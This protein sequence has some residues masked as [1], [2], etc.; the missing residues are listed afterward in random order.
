MV[1][2]LFLYSSVYSCHLFLISSASV[3]FLSLPSFTVPILTWNVPFLSPIFLKRSLVFPILLFSSISL[4][5]SLKKAYLSLLFS[6]T[7]HSVGY[8]FPCL[9]CFLHIFFPQLFVRPPQTTTLSWISFSLGW[10][11]SLTP[12]QCYKLLLESQ[13]CHSEGACITQLSNECRV[14]LPKTDGS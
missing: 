11:W 8:T 4:H 9:P 10:F 5:C 14:G 13:P 1:S 12:V 6:G 2:R 7:L 3:K